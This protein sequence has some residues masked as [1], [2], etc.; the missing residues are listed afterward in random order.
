MSSSSLDA[1]GISLDRNEID[2]F[3]LPSQ[4]RVVWDEEACDVVKAGSN[5]P[6]FYN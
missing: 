6:S 5:R 1:A 4:K 2:A 3:T